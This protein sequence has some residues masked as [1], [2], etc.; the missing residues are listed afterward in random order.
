[1][2]DEFER[3]CNSVRYLLDTAIGLKTDKQSPNARY[4]NQ[5]INTID[6]YKTN[7]AAM[8]QAVQTV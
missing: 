5:I 4:F 8:R 2:L 1:M 7:M 3:M 6:R